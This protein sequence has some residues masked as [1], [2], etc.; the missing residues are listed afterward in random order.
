MKIRVLLD[1]LLLRLQN[2]VRVRIPPRRLTLITIT[3]VLAFKSHCPFSLQI[4]IVFLRI[5]EEENPT[6]F[7]FHF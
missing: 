6:P 1:L 5:A 7:H 2:R 4:S 3:E